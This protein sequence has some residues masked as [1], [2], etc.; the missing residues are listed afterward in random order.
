MGKQ[1][2]WMLYS[3]YHYLSL[4]DLL[5]GTYRCLYSMEQFK[6]LTER[7]PLHIVEKYPTAKVSFSLQDIQ[8]RGTCKEYMKPGMRVV[9]LLQ[10]CRPSLV[11]MNLV[12]VKVGS[13]NYNSLMN[14]LCGLSHSLRHLSL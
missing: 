2:K 10:L 8:H 11:L 6:E 1:R 12:D 5:K 7:Q 9:D 3:F 14:Y 4:Q 13:I